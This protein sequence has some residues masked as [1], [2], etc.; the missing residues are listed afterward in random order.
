MKQAKPEAARARIP[1]KAEGEALLRTVIE[2][3]GGE[4]NRAAMRADRD[5]G[6]AYLEAHY[7]ELLA[8]YPDEQIA[9]LRDRVVVHA[10]EQ[11]EFGRL[12]EEY[13][14][15]EGT[16]PARLYGRYMASDPPLLAV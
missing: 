12:L 1:D 3:F 6:R 8:R 10:A 5:A 14:A 11:Q 13:L 7:D 15:E 9:V 2:A 4:E 16:D